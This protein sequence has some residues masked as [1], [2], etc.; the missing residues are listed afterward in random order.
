MTTA[1]KRTWR[2]ASDERLYAPVSCS[3]IKKSHALR[4]PR[5]RLFLSV[6]DRRP[7]GAG[8]DRDVIEAELPRVVEVDACRRSERR[9]TCVSESL[10]RERHVEDA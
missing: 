1:G 6:D 10:P 9:R 5:T 3:A 4:M 8:G 7:A 2:F